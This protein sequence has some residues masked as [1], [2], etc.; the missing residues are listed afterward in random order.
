MML[1]VMFFCIHLDTDQLPGSPSQTVLN[2]LENVFEAVP[3]RNGAL[4]YIKVHPKRAD[5]TLCKFLKTHDE[6]VRY[7]LVHTISK[8]VHRLGPLSKAELD[9]RVQEAI[10]NHR[11]FQAVFFGFYDAFVDP[12]KSER[13]AVDRESFLDLV[14][15]FMKPKM[16]TPV[17][18]K[19]SSSYLCIIDRKPAELESEDLI[20]RAYA[21]QV[22]FEV[23]GSGSKKRA[24]SKMWQAVFDQQYPKH[25]LTK[26]VEMANHALKEDKVFQDT[27]WLQ[28]RDQFTLFDF[29]R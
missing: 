21:W 23:L 11:S 20:L 3:S 19:R 12:Q 16:K 28:A 29:V 27:I 4:D 26:A 18:P 9:Q 10:Q 6:I 17:E 7:L 8:Q 2:Q 5:R 14:A 24:F 15:G 22:A 13:I 25:G 1:L